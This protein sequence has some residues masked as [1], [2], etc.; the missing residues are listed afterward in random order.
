M[1]GEGAPDK[2]DG[3][4]SVDTAKAKPDPNAPRKED[5]SEGSSTEDDEESK[6]DSDKP[7]SD[8]E[9]GDDADSELEA[10]LREDS[11]IS[12]SA[13]SDGEHPL[14]V[15]K[16]GK[17]KGHS[18]DESPISTIAVLVVACWTLRIPVMLRDFTRC[19]LAAVTVFNLYPHLCLK[20]RRA[21]S[22]S[23]LRSDDTNLPCEPCA[24][25][26]QAQRASTITPGMRL[27]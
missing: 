26:H 18:T 14:S 5:D 20:T 21:V 12:S 7:E 17:R 16:K 19:V 13:S 25:S 11:E 22:T 6:K 23:I 24:A 4:P 2:G 15:H 1:H 27:T 10:L 8:E 3:R 9:G